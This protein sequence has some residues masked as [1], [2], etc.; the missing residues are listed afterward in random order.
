MKVFTCIDDKTRN[1]FVYGLLESCTY[2]NLDLHVSFP[3]GSGK[4]E[5]HREKDLQFYKF[6]S[7][8]RKNELVLFTDGFDTC[9]LSD[10][11]EIL[12][13]YEYLDSDIV[14][15]A[16]INCHPCSELETLYLN[17]SVSSSSYRYLNSGGIIGRVGSLMKVI[18]GFSQIEDTERGKAYF[19]SNQYL[20]TMAYLLRQH[21][22]KLDTNCLIFQTFST[23]VYNLHK[24]IGSKDDYQFC[25]SLIRSYKDEFFNNFVFDDSRI[26]NKLTQTSPSHLHFNSPFLKKAMFQKRFTSIFPWFE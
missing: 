8:C 13:K 21:P 19:W 1:S 9:F 26:F 7:K 14:V 18:E 3:T 16:E 12:N 17:N 24:I 15:S 11:T 23:D 25:L 20:W 6:L 2:F 10:A 4:W 5:S 22:I